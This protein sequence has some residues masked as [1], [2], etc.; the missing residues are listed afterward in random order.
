MHMNQKRLYPCAKMNVIHQ[1]GK[2]HRSQSFLKPAITYTQNKIPD[3][4]TP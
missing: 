1:Y 3:R 2:L 4:I